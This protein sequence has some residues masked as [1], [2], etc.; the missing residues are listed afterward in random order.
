MVANFARGKTF[1]ELVEAAEEEFASRDLPLK[2]GA[3]EKLLRDRVEVVAAQIGVSPQSALRYFSA[4]TIRELAR[5]T[6]LM[7]KEHEAHVDEQ[8]PVA[9][10][11]QQAGLVLS[12]F[13]VAAR[14]GAVNGDP[15]V[16]ADLCEVITGVS[17]ALRSSDQVEMSALLLSKGLMWAS[18]P[19]EKLVDGDWAVLPGKTSR[20]VD[21]QLAGQLCRDLDAIRG[22]L[23]TA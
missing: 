23:S 17:M 5:K 19:A 22:L 10:T 7:R 2:P 6:V 21:L 12:A 9:L 20:D 11:V 18:L 1:R 14:L 15:D 13:T 16:A 8:S 4:E 3:A